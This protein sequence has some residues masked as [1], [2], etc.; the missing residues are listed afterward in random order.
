MNPDKIL[1]RSKRDFEKFQE[2]TDREL[3]E[4]NRRAEK[5]LDDSKLNYKEWRDFLHKYFTVIVA[6]IGAT[7]ILRIELFLNSFWFK[8]GIF[9]ALA[10]VV[11]GYLFVN[12]YF[13]L[14]RKWLDANNIFES[15]KNLDFFD[16]PDSD[17]DFVKSVRL[18]IKDK[19]KKAK[20]NKKASKDRKEIDTIKKN[21]YGLKREYSIMKYVGQQFLLM[22][23]IWV[24]GVVL[25]FL[26]SSIGI[27]FIFIGLADNTSLMCG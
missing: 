12:L 20:E 19:L 10:G 27:V 13:W 25:S 4:N 6:L 14:E 16:H 23:K 18:H 3:N 15:V 1:E 9:L 7:G 2:R 17:G 26:L 11:L 5:L 22:E 24:W 8:W 21:I